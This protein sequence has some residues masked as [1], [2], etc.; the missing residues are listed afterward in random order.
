MLR[1]YNPGTSLTIHGILALL[2]VPMILFCLIR[3]LKYLAPFSALAN[4][5][6][7]GSLGVILYDLIFNGQLKPIREL[8]MVAPVQTWPTFFSSAVYAFEGIACVMP[9]YHGMQSKEFFTPI[10]GVLNTSMFITAIIYYVVGFSGYLKYG[11]DC[12]PSI[13]LNLAVENVS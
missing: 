7:I 4:L 1:H 3:D 13:T 10:H 12:K 2:L 11:N 5:I 6:M 9:V 8:V